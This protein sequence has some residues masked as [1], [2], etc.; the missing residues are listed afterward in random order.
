M[1]ITAAAVTTT[2]L[3]SASHFSVEARRGS[4]IA[5]VEVIAFSIIGSGTILTADQG[6]R[7][8]A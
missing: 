6:N 2:K 1:R 4:G 7:D 8:T 3:T 5:W